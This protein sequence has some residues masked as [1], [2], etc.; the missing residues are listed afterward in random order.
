MGAELFSKCV[1]DSKTKTKPNQTKDFD[2]RQ[3]IL[4]YTAFAYVQG[5]ITAQVF[6]VASCAQSEFEPPI[7]H[8]VVWPPRRC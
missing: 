4:W 5:L 1:G 2:L 6:E 7:V 8:E 3:V